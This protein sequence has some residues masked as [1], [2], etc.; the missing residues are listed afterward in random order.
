M[1]Q[2]T[3]EC[4]KQIMIEFWNSWWLNVWNIWWLIAPVDNWQ[5]TYDKLQMT[6]DIMKDD[7]RLMTDERCHMTEDRQLTHGIRLDVG[8]HTDAR[9]G[10]H[11]Y[12]RLRLLVL[13]RSMGISWRSDWIL[14]WH[15]G[16][17][18]LIV[19]KLPKIWHFLQK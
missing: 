18:H 17:Y 11:Q 5:I 7:R 15:S 14:T 3:I 10:P 12:H 13:W 19:K 1:K 9:P 6:D 2:L 16:N 8:D 4:V